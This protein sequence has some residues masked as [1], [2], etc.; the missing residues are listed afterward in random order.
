M[1]WNSL[2]GKH[3]LLLQSIEALSKYLHF[4]VRL[5]HNSGQYSYHQVLK[6]PRAHNTRSLLGQNTSLLTLLA[7]EYII[8]F[9]TRTKTWPRKTTWNENEDF[10]FVFF[11]ISFYINKVSN[12]NDMGR[13]IL[14]SYKNSHR[15]RKKVQEWIYNRR[16]VQ[17]E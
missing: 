10:S 4:K 13:E 8:I 5:Q 14:S 17:A 2:T 16:W 3:N 11:S 7:E 12:V 6:Q 15:I 9:I 1:K